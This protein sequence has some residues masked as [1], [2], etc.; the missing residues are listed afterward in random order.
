MEKHYHNFED[1]EENKF[2]YTDIFK[3]YVRVSDILGGRGRRR[4]QTSEICCFIDHQE[5]VS[6]WS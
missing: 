5:G 2:I 6:G 3:Q 4:G 1:T